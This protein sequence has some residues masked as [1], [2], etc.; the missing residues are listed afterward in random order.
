MILTRMKGKQSSD[1][2]RK[3]KPELFGWDGGR[4]REGER[5]RERKERSKL[6]SAL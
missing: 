6:I 5:N 3:N 2:G 4:E 1:L